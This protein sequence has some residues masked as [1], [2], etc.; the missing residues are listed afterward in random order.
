MKIKT[1]I[2]KLKAQLN[3]RECD[4]LQELDKNEQEII[5]VMETQ[6]ADICKINV[7]KS[8]QE[9]AEAVR[10][11]I[12]QTVLAIPYLKSRVLDTC[13][14]LPHINCIIPKE[15]T[16]IPEESLNAGWLQM[17]DNLD[18]PASPAESENAKPGRLCFYRG[19]DTEHYAMLK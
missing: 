2:C 5:K 10:G 4:L 19:R 11:V 12:E 17:E 9:S 6:S 16:F 8:L 18:N 15:V 13:T 1:H 3:Q 7:L 14:S